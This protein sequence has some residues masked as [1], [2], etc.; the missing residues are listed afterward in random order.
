M[1]AAGDQS[2][3]RRH[4]NVGGSGAGS[5]DPGGSGAGSTD[6]AASLGHDG[7]RKWGAREDEPSAST[8]WSWTAGDEVALGAKEKAKNAENLAR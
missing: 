4:T 1:G 7:R 5:T 3:Q 2:Q 6:P 8:A